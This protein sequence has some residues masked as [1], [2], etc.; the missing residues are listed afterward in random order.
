ME[1]WD[2]KNDSTKRFAPLFTYNILNNGEDYGTNIEDYYPL[3]ESQGAIRYDEFVVPNLNSRSR[4][5]LTWCTDTDALTNALKYRVSNTVDD[6]FAPDTLNTPITSPNSSYLLRLKEPL[7]L[8]YVIVVKVSSGSRVFD[9]YHNNC[10]KNAYWDFRYASN[11][12]DIVCTRVNKDSADA[13][14]YHAM[15]IVGYDDSIWYDYNGN[16]E[17]E[18]FELGAFK[19]A[20]SWGTRYANNGFIWV[21]YDALN[22]VSNYA[23]NNTIPNYYRAEAFI[24]YRYHY[25]DVEERDCSLMAKVSLDQTRRNEIQLR[26]GDNFNLEPSTYTRELYTFLNNRGGAKPIE[27]NTVTSATFPFDFSYLANKVVRSN[28]YVITKDTG[29][30]GVTYVNHVVLQDKTGH[31]VVDDTTTSV[32]NYLD[33]DV[34]RYRIGLLGDVNNNGYADMADATI[35]Q[36]LTLDMVNLSDDDLRVADVNKMV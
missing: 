19:L 26:L 10:Y 16:G 12:E 13:L 20:N 30:T 31:I 3:L 34:R 9:P 36:R 7:N 11:G 17:Q 33:E 4:Y 24:D 8:G 27:G 22:K 25:M 23:P 29:T 14:A 18:S 5:Y 28:Y 21:M 32:V 35:I 6:V 15:T 2:A 1:N